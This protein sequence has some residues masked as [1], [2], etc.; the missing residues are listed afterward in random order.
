[1]TD[2]SAQ[3]KALRAS[4]LAKRAA[5]LPTQKAQMDAA[6][7]DRIAALAAFREADLIL[8]FFPVRGEVDL[9]PLYRLAAELHIPLAFPRCEG[10]EMTFHIVANLDELVPDRFRIPAPPVGAPLA[11][12]TEKTLCLLPGLAATRDGARLG[13]G[14]GFYDRFLPRFA[15]SLI[16]PVYAQFVL[17]TLPS[18]A[19]DQRIP[20][21]VT[22]KGEC[23]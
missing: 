12:C 1:M 18:E 10:K 17:D 22:E 11:V 15:G 23:L 4:L 21:I 9:R 14:G 16:F 7:C 5:I 20:H 8:A 13:Y 19:H 6:I 2:V 3:K